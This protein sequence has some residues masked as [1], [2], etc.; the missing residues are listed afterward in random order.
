MQDRRWVSRFA[1]NPSYT[2]QAI[3]G[4]YYVRGKTE[5]RFS[6]DDGAGRA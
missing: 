6:R 5:G 2:L 1:L 3:A 4:V